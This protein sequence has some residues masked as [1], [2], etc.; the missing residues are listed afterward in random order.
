MLKFDSEAQLEWNKSYGGSG[1]DRGSSIIETSDGGYALLGYSD[2]TDGDVSSNN[3]NRDFW[4]VKITASGVL[5]WQKSF[6]YEGLDEGVSVIETS[7]NHLMLSGVLDVTAS[8]GEG[9]QGRLYNRHAGGDYWCRS[10]HCS[11]KLSS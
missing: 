9:N 1:D 5:T 6:G 4:L 3:G 8:G 2:S 11:K 10:S 7:D